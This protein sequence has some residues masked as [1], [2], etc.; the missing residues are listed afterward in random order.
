M[1]SG[2]SSRLHGFFI[3]HTEALPNIFFVFKEY[4]CQFV[5]IKVKELASIITRPYY[6]DKIESWLGKEAVSNIH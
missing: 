3:S 2:P 5:V 4:S 6:A 1:H